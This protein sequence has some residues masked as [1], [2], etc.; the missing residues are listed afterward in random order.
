MELHL[1]L[2]NVQPVCVVRIIDAF[3]FTVSLVN[4]VLLSP[5]GDES[6]DFFFFFLTSSCRTVS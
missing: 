2:H 5:S 3:I 4:T 6:T 1:Q